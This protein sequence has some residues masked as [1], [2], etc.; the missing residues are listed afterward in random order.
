[1]PLHPHR[2][3]I[4]ACIAAVLVPSVAQ[5]AD[6]AKEKTLS[7]T[8]LYPYRFASPRKDSL[9]AAT[10]H[11]RGEIEWS[12]PLD[13]AE[14][15]GPAALL[16]WQDRVVVDAAGAALVYATDGRLLWKRP[17]LGRMPVAIANDSLNLVSA[18]RELESYDIENR[19]RRAAVPL[20]VLV[21]DG[22]QLNLLWPQA[23]DFMASAYIPRPTFDVE[24]RRKPAPQ[25]KLMVGRTVYG[26]TMPA[27]VEGFKGAL[28]LPPLYDPASREWL[29]GYDQIRV[30]DAAGGQ[31]LASFALP[32]A[33]PS[34]WSLDSQGSVCVAG[35]DAAGYKTVVTLGNRGARQWA[36]TD[37][38]PGADDPWSAD[39]PPI[40]VAPGR[41]IMLTQG[42]V[43]AID[44]GLL[45]WTY[46]ARS[47]GLRH[48]ASTTDGSFEVADGRLKST[49][50]LR[51]GTALAD[52]SVLVT[53][54]R[55]LRHI[56]AQG[57][58]LF[59]LSLPEEAVAPPV[60]DATGHVYVATAKALY[61]IR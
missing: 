47:D 3:L 61:R 54:R 38:D 33:T 42:R 16:L 59:S 29:V 48:G 15:G 8:S 7:I 58:R 28:K 52:G 49:E 44:A 35:L 26:K 37:S 57:R 43:L 51:Y 45:V 6:V 22:F 10:T 1:M 2:L 56:D 60:V 32:V 13:V 12:R 14:D 34:G 18:L 21:T 50:R 9:S 17:K 4:A 19:A 55:S 41:V 5:A 23:E 36:W 46:D 11:A 39:Q 31:P 25:P 53:G 40:R 20:S 24:D 27:W 30:L